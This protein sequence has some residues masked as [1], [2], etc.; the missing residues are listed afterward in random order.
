MAQNLFDTQAWMVV[1]Q[2]GTTHVY[3][4]FFIFKFHYQGLRYVNAFFYFTFFVQWYAKPKVQNFMQ[5][6]ISFHCYASIILLLYNI[7][8]KWQTLYTHV[9]GWKCVNKLVVIEI[10]TS[11]RRRL[12]ILLLDLHKTIW[13]RRVCLIGW[14]DIIIFMLKIIFNKCLFLQGIGCHKIYITT[15]NF[16]V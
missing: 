14:F 9:I 5:L 3:L 8:P 13:H 1:P 11:F 10:K 2:W 12:K 15:S 6:R 7:F 16:I 4:L